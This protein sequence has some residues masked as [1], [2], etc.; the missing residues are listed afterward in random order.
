MMVCRDLIAKMIE[1]KEREKQN[2]DMNT[3]HDP[4]AR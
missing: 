1:W 3:L 2:D 4:Q